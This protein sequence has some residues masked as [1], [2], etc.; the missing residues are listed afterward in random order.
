[1]RGLK[2]AVFVFCAFAVSPGAFAST[3]TSYTG[4]DSNVGP[5]STL[6]NSNAAH[7]AFT[8]ASAP[9]GVSDLITF[10]SAPLGNFTSLALGSGATLTLSNTLAGTFDNPGITNATDAFLGFNTTAGGAK[11]F[12]MAT[13]FI[14]HGAT[15][16][17][18]ATFSFVSPIDAFG[19]YFTGLGGGGDT[20][21]L[22][23]VDGSSETLNLSDTSACNNPSCA[24]FFGFTDAGAQISSIVLN[25]A[26]T[27]QESSGTFGYFIGVDDVQFSTVPEPASLLLFGSGIAVL[28]RRRRRS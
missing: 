3:I 16:N 1:M 23:F 8:T 14:G 26:Y 24:E 7:A 12:R 11:F 20:V 21:S 2:S 18:T 15:T 9:L 5:A 27:N 10:E 6:A 19:G 25:M 22:N 17:A 28:A 4:I 13:N